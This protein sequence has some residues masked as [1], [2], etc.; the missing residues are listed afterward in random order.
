M[1]ARLGGFRRAW[2]GDAVGLA[3]IAE[4]DAE[5]D[6]YERWSHVQGYSLRR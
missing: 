6:M 3:V 1:K 2:S 4:L 5:I